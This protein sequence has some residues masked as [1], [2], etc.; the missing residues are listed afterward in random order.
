[1]KP[2]EKIMRRLIVLGVC[3]LWSSWAFTEDNPKG[4]FRSYVFGD[5]YGEAIHVYGDNYGTA[6]GSV[7]GDN[8]GRAPKVYGDTRSGG[9]SLRTYG[10]T[11][12]RGNSAVTHGN[13]H[14]RYRGNVDWVPSYEREQDRAAANLLKLRQ[15]LGK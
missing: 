2:V 1:M 3:L 8:Y 15:L 13:N 6:H 12:P 10:D 5:N 14:G 4:S 9:R 7:R 11:R